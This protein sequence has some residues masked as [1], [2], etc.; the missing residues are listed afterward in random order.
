MYKTPQH[1]DGCPYAKASLLSN[2]HHVYMIHH[3]IRFVNT[4]F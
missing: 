2:I 3:L 4:L 1:T